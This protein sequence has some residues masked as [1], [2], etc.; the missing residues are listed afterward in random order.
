[1][2]SQ[3]F[4]DLTTLDDDVN[5]GTVGI[6]FKLAPRW[7]VQ[8]NAIYDM[9]Y[10]DFKSHSGGLFYNHPC[11]YLSVQYRRDNTKKED[12]VGTTTY[13]FRFGMSIDGKQY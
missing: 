3:R 2:W 10:G 7:A 8:W 6:G 9:A 13:Q 5:E 12:Y 11:Y 4:I 1:M